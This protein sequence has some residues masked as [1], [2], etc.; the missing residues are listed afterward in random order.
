MKS[1][2]DIT[3]LVLSDIELTPVNRIAIFMHMLM[4]KACGLFQQQT[5]SI[6]RALSGEEPSMQLD[7]KARERI[8]E[9]ILSK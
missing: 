2:R 6:D 8:K 5:D 9:Q 3:K 7:E 4:C 1:C